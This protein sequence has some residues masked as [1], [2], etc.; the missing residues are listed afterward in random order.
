MLDHHFAER[1]PG[2]SHIY[3]LSAASGHSH[4]FEHSHAHYD[5]LYAPASGDEGIVFFAPLDGAG[6][7][8]A[9]LVSP[10]ATPVF[11][12]DDGDVL[13]IMGG[14][15]AVPVLKGAFVPPRLLPP[16]A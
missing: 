5:A 9:G 2:H 11:P 6:H 7:P 13:L 3:L 8:P 12:F 15:G 16:K 4:P 14:S 1:H 10:V